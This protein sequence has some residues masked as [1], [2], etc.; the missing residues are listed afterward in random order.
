MGS[1]LSPKFAQAI[2]TQ[3]WSSVGTTHL[4]NELLPKYLV[5]VPS[6]ANADPACVKLGK[7]NSFE[8]RLKFYNGNVKI[9]Q[10]LINLGKLGAAD[11]IGSINN[12]KKFTSFKF[13]CNEYNNFCYED[14]VYLDYNNVKTRIKTFIY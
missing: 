14:S 2:A 7:I 5:F 6:A 4:V 13:E 8:S 12:D 1:P 3:L 9:E 11:I 10:F